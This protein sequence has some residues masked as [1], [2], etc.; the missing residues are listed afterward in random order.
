LQPLNSVARRRRKK[1]QNFVGQTTVNVNYVGIKSV[2][3]EED[4]VVNT[5]V[6][7]VGRKTWEDDSARKREH[8]LD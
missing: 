6:E 2:D 3:A 8:E 5:V 7:N 1:T 4:S